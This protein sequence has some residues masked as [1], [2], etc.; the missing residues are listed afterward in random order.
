M[1]QSLMIG[2]LTPV[3]AILNQLQ[4]QWYLCGSVASSIHGVARTTVD[5][6]IVADLT[7]AHVNPLIENLQDEFYISQSAVTE[8]IARKRSFN[9]IHLTTSFK[10]DV[11]AL[12]SRA[13]DKHTI[14]RIRPAVLSEHG[15]DLPV[16]VASA[17]DTILSKLEW[18]RKG[19][20]ISERQWEDILG[21]FRIQ[22][23]AL[24]LDYLKRWSSDIGVGDLLDRAYR[25]LQ[26]E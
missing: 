5:A 23:N 1:Q 7:I 13:F 6:D 15:E 14:A 16:V 22:R 10:V 19:N 24:E 26:P 3:A 9:A 17:E 2:A 4:V 12:K 20:E 11:F 21:I 18:Y 8:A 25:E